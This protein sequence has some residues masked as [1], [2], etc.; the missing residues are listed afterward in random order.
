MKKAFTKDEIYTIIDGRIKD[1]MQRKNK[2]I[3]LNGYKHKDILKAFDTEIA[4][5][6]RLYGVF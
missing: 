1:A 4:T 3:E 6:T 2:Y 5:L